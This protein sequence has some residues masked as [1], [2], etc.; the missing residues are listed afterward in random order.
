[1]PTSSTHFRNVIRSLDKSDCYIWVNFELNTARPIQHAVYLEKI[2]DQDLAAMRCMIPY[3]DKT[4]KLFSMITE[5]LERMKIPKAYGYMPQTVAFG[6]GLRKYAGSLL[7]RN[8]Y[9][10]SSLDDEFILLS[11]LLRDLGMISTQLEGDARDW[12][13]G[14]LRQPLILGMSVAKVSCDAAQDHDHDAQPED[15]VR[16]DRWTFVLAQISSSRTP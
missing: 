11:E 5:R 10:E 2:G 12:R 3:F 14:D 1:M 7:R 4:G 16:H 15:K 13:S 6:R 9:H 8:V